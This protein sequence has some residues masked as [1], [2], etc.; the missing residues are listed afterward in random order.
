[1]L[2]EIT[3]RSFGIEGGY[4]DLNRILV[5]SIDFNLFEFLGDS[6]RPMRIV[7]SDLRA[8]L[9]DDARGRLALGAL[10]ADQPGNAELRDWVRV[11]LPDLLD[12]VSS[13]A[14]EAAR[15]AY[16]QDRLKR[17]VGVIQS[18]LSKLSDK[19]ILPE[20]ARTLARSIIQLLADLNGY[21]SVHDALHYVQMS[22]LSELQRV[23]AAT[24]DPSE[25]SLVLGLQG[26][27]IGL[28]QDR[29]RRQFDDPGAPPAARPESDRAEQDLARIATMIHDNDASTSET[30][31][32]AYNLLRGVLR[33]QM[34]LF[35]S[36]LVE[37]SEKIPFA[38]F[39]QI[40]RGLAQ[41]GSPTVRGEEPI[42]LSNVGN[43]F[44]DLAARL[45]M[46]QTVHRLWQRVEATL[47]NV[48]ELLRGTGG[49]LEIRFHWQ[50]LKDLLNQIAEQGRSGEPLTLLANNDLSAAETGTL[51][52]IRSDAFRKA[53]AYMA[54]A[55]RV[56]FQRADNALLEDCGLLSGLAAPLKLLLGESR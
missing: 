2:E 51:D 55:A 33:L 24:V 12:R 53:F 27:E 28:A 44:D 11:N 30:A 38:Q 22:V 15:P 20:Q 50:N 34:S 43:S 19:I 25:R 8:E 35:D 42:L 23:A 56:R 45:Q 5:G 7:I 47:L 13:A 4:K 16:E 46:R 6:D 1:M 36:R 39:A 21:K 37:T 9:Q 41:P 48:E 31:D 18:T 52:T 54:R 3:S 17:R 14:F 32:A 10:Y 29:I 49:E 26:D 40:L